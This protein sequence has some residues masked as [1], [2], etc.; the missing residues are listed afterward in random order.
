[1]P[2][3][4]RQRKRPKNVAKPN[5]MRQALLNAAALDRRRQAQ[6]ANQIETINRLL[7]SPHAPGIKYTEEMKILHEAGAALVAENQELRE[8]VRELTD[9]ILDRDGITVEALSAPVSS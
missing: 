7:S 8:K 4:S 5:P 3:S 9:Q 2:E 1:M 6:I